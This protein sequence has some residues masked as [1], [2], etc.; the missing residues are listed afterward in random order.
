MTRQWFEI[1][2]ENFIMLSSFLEYYILFIGFVITIMCCC[3]VRAVFNSE[4]KVCKTTLELVLIEWTDKSTYKPFNR[5]SVGWL[6]H[7]DEKTKTIASHL[8]GETQHAGE[9]II[10]TCI[11]KKIK[12]IA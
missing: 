12:K 4:R 6:V 11:I 9:F 7:D 2:K 3:M 10:P 8:I 1:L 5:L